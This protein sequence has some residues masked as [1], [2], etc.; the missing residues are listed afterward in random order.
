MKMVVKVVEVI[1][2]EK[3]RMVMA[4]GSQVLLSL[5]VTRSFFVTTCKR[6]N[7]TASEYPIN[8]TQ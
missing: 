2:Y 3:K 7:G 4:C 6:W 8:T 1:V 5:S